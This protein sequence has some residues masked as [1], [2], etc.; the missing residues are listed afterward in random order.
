M[1]AR[2]SRPAGSERRHGLESVKKTDQVASS[3]GMGAIQI[4]R[5]LIG[6]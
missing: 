2:L 1:T 6:P 3:M 4:G 5:R